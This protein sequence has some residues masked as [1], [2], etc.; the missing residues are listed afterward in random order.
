MRVK[1]GLVV[2]VT[3]VVAACGGGDVSQQVYDQKVAELA[4]AQQNLLDAR[5]ELRRAVAQGEALD[6]LADRYEAAVLEALGLVG[7]SVP[8]GFD[9]VDALAEAVS[10]TSQERDEL[11]E[12]MEGGSE[13]EA[14]VSTDTDRLSAM[15]TI[16]TSVLLF[17][18]PQPLPDVATIQET[19]G[20][21]V[22]EVSDEMITIAYDDLIVAYDEGADEERLTELLNGLG[23]WALQMASSE[24]AR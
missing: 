1:I 14:T 6:D 15:V 16:A 12:S 7:M 3:F 20:P 17:L 4:L 10:A 5:Q 8:E 22:G 11:L 2:A 9:R 24:L 19:F 23:Y 18:P 13:S 21:L